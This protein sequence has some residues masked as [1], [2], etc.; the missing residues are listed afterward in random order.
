MRSRFSFIAVHIIFPLL[1]GGLIYVCWRD[2]NLPMFRW[3][4]LAG[5]GPL[6]KQLRIAAAPLRDR[7]PFWFR[8]SLP[9]AMWVYSLTAFMTLVWKDVDSRT[10]AL[11]ISM[12]LLFGAGSELGQL[13]GY[14]PGRFDMF[15][16]VFCVCAAGLAV[17]FTSKRFSFKRSMNE[18]AT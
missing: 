9:D 2:H 3:F 12:G 4:D 7:L 5:L 16:F 17:L 8:F 18:A 10:K 15:D 13:A 14:V 6:V 1:L 11:W